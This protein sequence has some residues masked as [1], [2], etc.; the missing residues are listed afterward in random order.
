M[1]RRHRGHAD[2]RA[3]HRAAGIRRLRSPEAGRTQWTEP[4]DCQTL[5]DALADGFPQKFG[6]DAAKSVTPRSWR[7][8][9]YIAFERLGEELR[10]SVPTLIST[11]Q[12]MQCSEGHRK[13]SGRP[14]IAGATPQRIEGGKF[15]RHLMTRNIS[16]NVS[17][18][19]RTNMPSMANRSS[20]SRRSQIGRCQS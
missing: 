11:G 9:L 17:R 4:S 12:Q 8:V 20:Q 10:P 7:A 3:S 16:T 6:A 15:L 13:C 19:A 5:P 2:H 14:G 18:P 1:E